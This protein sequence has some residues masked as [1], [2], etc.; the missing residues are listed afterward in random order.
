MPKRLLPLIPSGLA[1]VQVLPTT[2]R[3]TITAQPRTPSAACPGCGHPSSAVHSF[4]ER[5]LHDLPWQGRPVVL[6]IRARRFRCLVPACE[7]LTF[8]ERL[9]GVAF[10]AARRTERLD[11]LHGCLG[12][13]LGGEAGAR[14]ARRLAI[15]TS[16]DT[17]LRAIRARA[18]AASPPPPPRVLGVDDYAWRRGHRYGTVLVDLERNRIVDLLPD[19]QAA[20]LAAWLRA[21]PGVE[22]IARDRAGAYAD[23]ARQGAPG[24]VQVADRW[25]M[26]RNLGDAVHALADRHGAAVRRVARHAAEDSAEQRTAAPPP[27]PAAHRP[28]AAER[29]KAAS[30]ARRQARYEEAARLRGQGASIRRIAALL[31]AE[32][33]TVRGWLS[34]GGAAT[35][36]KPK[37]GSALDPYAPVLERR[38][39][40][41][42]RNATQLW[43][44]VA[45]AGYRG[46]PGTVRTWAAEHRAAKP[47]GVSGR[48]AAAVALSA[49]PPSGRRVGR[50]LMADD[51]KLGER[52]RR[53][54]A[55][56]LAEAPRLA[57]AVAI[58]KRLRAVLRKTGDEPLTAVLAAAK[59]TQLASFANGLERDRDAV[60]AALDL[61]WTTSPVEGQVNRI[62]TVKRS[63]YGRAGFDLLHARVLHAA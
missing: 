54:V 52:E 19:R 5:R 40:E 9:P 50:W 39:A 42:C 63:M 38:W 8:A 29:A 37:R 55:R 18:G 48:G 24:A 12:T 35:W 17:L 32:R 43:R 31:G 27:P 46:R 47:E 13:A 60:Q 23:G 61:P 6:R 34:R 41:G 11:G 2:D 26:L 58:A 3:V 57:E 62:K 44:E 20:T 49:A 56:L 51:G 59:A 30:F 16:P 14:L 33:V 28:T 22:I 36:T 1:V 7:R 10:A 45:A 21:H 15:A 25:H 53:F 4:Y